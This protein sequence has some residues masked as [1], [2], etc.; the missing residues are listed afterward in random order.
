M[1][2]KVTI[3]VPTFRRPQLLAKCLQA[4]AAQDFDK[5]DYEVI[6][7]SDG[8]DPGTEALVESFQA[9][10]H[11]A[12][13]HL[14]SHKGPAAARNKGWREA[15]S[16][17]IAFTDDDCLPDTGW[18][19]ALWQA[20]KHSPMAAFTGRIEVPVSSLPTDFE[21][22]TMGLETAEF[23]TANCAV[24]KE[25]LIRCGGFDENFTMAWREDSDLEFK[26]IALGI[27]IVR[28]ADALVVHPVRKAPWG[29]SIREQKKGLFDALLFKKIPGLIPS[30]DPP[31]ETL[32]ILPDHH[33]LFWNDDRHVFKN[34]LHDSYLRSNLAVADRRPYPPATGPHI[35]QA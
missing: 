14:E 33:M 1:N 23:V 19:A 15:R 27:T 31:L 28:V 22:N 26:L 11:L 18:L 29:V 21:R 13:L 24:S 20:F 4:L 34:N 16:S 8:P 12:F 6:V 2:R 30:K 32:E 17:L 9:Y 25:A 5:E 10:I 7:V 3:V 35:P